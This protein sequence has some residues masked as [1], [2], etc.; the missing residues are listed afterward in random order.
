MAAAI[1][2]YKR[3]SKYNVANKVE[4]ASERVLKTEVEEHMQMHTVASVGLS[5]EQDWSPHVTIPSVESIILPQQLT[6]TLER[7][8]CCS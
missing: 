6:V 8:C 4:V 1:L 3:K 2:W 5:W 7:I